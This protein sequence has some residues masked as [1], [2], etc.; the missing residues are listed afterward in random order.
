MTTEYFAEVGIDRPI[1]RPYFIWRW[2]RR[3]YSS[4]QR[5]DRPTRQWVEDP[6]LACYTHHGEIGSEPITKE[7]AM[8]LISRWSGKEQR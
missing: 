2:V 8:E 1:D 7:K 6:S 3:P 4:H 5:Y